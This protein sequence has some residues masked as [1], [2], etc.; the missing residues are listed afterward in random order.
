M[1]DEN[2]SRSGPDFRHYN[3]EAN[4]RIEPAVTGDPELGPLKLLPGTW[5]NIRIDDR[6]ADSD[7]PNP[8]FGNGASPLN[9]RGWN[10]IALPFFRDAGG[11]PYRLLMNQYNEVLQ[12]DTVDDKVPNRGINFGDGE[13][14]D[15]AVAAL[16]YTQQIRQIKADDDVTQHT[17]KDDVDPEQ[18][19]ALIDELPIHH[20][21]G[22][23]LHMK[24]QTVND[25]TIARLATIPH[26]NAANAIGKFVEIDEPP[27]I[28]DLSG[29]PEG[30][31]TFDVEDAVE[32]DF[33]VEAE[34]VYLGPYR[35]FIENKFLNL[36]GPK[37]GNELLQA[38]LGPEK[39]KIK[40]TT[41]LHFDTDVAE[42]GIHNI[43]FIERQAD[44]ALMRSTFWI[45][46]LDEDGPF[47]EPRLLLAY[48]QFVFLDFFQRRDGRTGL[49]RWPH[50]SINMMEKV[51]PPPKTMGL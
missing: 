36:F 4:R 49:I 11:P 33:P 35:H 8:F 23:F 43:P 3:L 17:L 5:A 12:F 15:Q 40:K 26:G 32:P 22:F 39:S 2:V 21:P 48:S 51:A 38:G 50:I 19:K 37:N 34:R 18:G 29:L 6:R 25:F 45:M 20:E 46:E 44:A 28:P 16:D 30:A 1:K 7:G 42:G 24:Q 10:M 41:E 14:T 47:G 31:S 27:T 9:G 13:N